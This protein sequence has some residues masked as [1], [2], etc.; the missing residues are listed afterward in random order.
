MTTFI[1]FLYEMKF[2]SK[3]RYFTSQN[4]AVLRRPSGKHCSRSCNI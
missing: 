1:L 3:R 2:S 4:Y